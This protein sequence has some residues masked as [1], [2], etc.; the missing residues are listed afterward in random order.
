MSFSNF[1]S[2]LLSGQ[3][4]SLLGAGLL[5]AL[6]VP[7]VVAASESAP[8]PK[9]DPRIEAFMKSARAGFGLQQSDS[10]LLFKVISAGGGPRP[11]VEDTI[12]LSVKATAP[13][14]KT[15]LPQLTGE[16]VR[17]AVRDLLP[18]LVEAVR[19]LTL[20]GKMVTVVPPTLSFGDAAWPAGVQPGI[21]LLFELS[22]EDIVVTEANTPTAN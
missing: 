20:G 18:G 5:L 8:A 17:V 6:F 22:L 1:V 7:L 10:G 13:D 4:S 12:V 16:H 14:G 11:R 21:P 9:A 2:P 19:M 15:P 3:R